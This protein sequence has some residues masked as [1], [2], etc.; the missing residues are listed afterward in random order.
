MRDEGECV[1]ASYPGSSSTLRGYLLAGTL[2]VLIY[3][4][5]TIQA[6][7]TRPCFH[8]AC[9]VSIVFMFL[10]CSIQILVMLLKAVS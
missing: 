6:H 5:S 2:H 9:Y 4:N 1:V 3:F 10:T 7:A 8:W